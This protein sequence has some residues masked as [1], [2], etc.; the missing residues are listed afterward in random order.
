MTIPEPTEKAIGLNPGAMRIKQ[1]PPEAERPSS[2]R[3]LDSVT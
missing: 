3:L 2:G 1:G